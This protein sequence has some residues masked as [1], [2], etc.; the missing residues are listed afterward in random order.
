MYVYMYL[1]ICLY[2]KYLYVYIYIY[3]YIRTYICIHKHTF[4]YKVGYLSKILSY[5]HFTQSPQHSLPPVNSCLF[6]IGNFP[7][8]NPIISGFLSENDLPL[9]ASY[10]S[11]P[12]STVNL[13]SIKDQIKRNKTKEPHNYSIFG[14]K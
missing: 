10:S 3:L 4:I 1:S 12:P 11:S 14:G 13:K 2:R 6:F 7:R 5:S 9:Q 8:K